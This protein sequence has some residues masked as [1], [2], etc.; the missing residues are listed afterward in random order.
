VDSWTLK[1][2]SMKELNNLLALL[3][4]NK[5]II[6]EIGG[7]TDAT[8]TDE[9][10]LVLSEKRAIAVVE[11]LKENG[12]SSDRLNYKGY[13]NSSPKGNNITSEG[14]KLNRRTEVQIIGFRGKTK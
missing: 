1:K 13:G 9:H 3:K 4:E 2:E 10:N 14:R 11:F 8:G 12:I 7:Y 6:V 5:D